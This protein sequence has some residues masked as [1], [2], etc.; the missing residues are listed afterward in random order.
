[1]LT[2]LPNRN[3]LIKQMAGALR[4]QQREPGVCALLQIEIGRLRQ[5]SETLGQR[6]ADEALTELAARMQRSLRSGDAGGR[7]DDAGGVGVMVSRVGADEYAA[8]L[9]GLRRVED[10]GGIARRLHAELSKPLRIEGRDWYPTVSIGV[11]ASPDDAN[12]AEDLMRTARSAAS[13][14]RERSGNGVGFYSSGQ[15]AAALERLEL[16]TQLHRAL[17]RGEFELHYQPKFDSHTRALSGCEALI[18]W[19]HPERGLV[20]PDKFIPVAEEVGLIE[21]IGA[22]VLAE[23]CRAAHRWL[24]AGTPCRVAV[25]IASPHFRDGL[26]LQDVGAALSAVQLPSGLLSIELTE[27]VLMGPAEDSLPV[28]HKLKALGI[29]I[30]LDDFGTGYSSLAYLKR[31]PLDELKIDRSFVNGLPL[32]TENAAIVRAVVAM[33]ASLG[34]KVVAEGVET[35][36]QAVFLASIGCHMCQGWLFSRALP[37]DTFTSLLQQH[38]GPAR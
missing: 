1:M 38:R 16:E 25:N 21:P 12:D 33:A 3:M 29:S 9:P 15:N 13:A 4:R 14:V 27:S 20:P 6:A 36:E 34:L 18:R 17:E 35:P 2:G 11:S 32:D 24:Q 37:E 10:A 23:A 19:R 28:L 5:L 26:L 7:I 31:M 8:L 30:A 22:W